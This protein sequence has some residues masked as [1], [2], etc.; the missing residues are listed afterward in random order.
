MAA[1][2]LD[3]LVIGGGPT[4]VTAAT[5]LTQGGCR[6]LLLDAEPVG[7][8]RR[9]AGETLRAARAGRMADW[10]SW[11][12]RSIFETAQLQDVSP[13]LRVHS[14]AG[15]LESWKKVNRI[16]S[17]GFVAVGRDGPGGLS[18]IW[19]AMT[20]RLD[21]AQLTSLGFDPSEFDE[22]YRRV[23]ARIGMSGPP[24]NAASAVQDPPLEPSASAALFMERS[25]RRAAASGLAFERPQ[26]AVLSKPRGPGG[27]CTL[28][29]ACLW[30]CPVGAIYDAS[31][32]LEA[33][34]SSP[35]FS[36]ESARVVSLARESGGWRVE[37]LRGREPITFRA[38]VVVVAAGH[39]TTSRL[40]LETLEYYERPIRFENSPAF[41]LAVVLPERVG[42]PTAERAFGMAQLVF[43]LKTDGRPQDEIFGAVYDAE[44]VA[45]S[46]LYSATFLSPG[47]IRSIAR[48]LTPAV[49][50]VFCYLPGGL[51]ENWMRLER[52]ASGPRLKV[53]GDIALDLKSALRR[54]ARR[55]SSAFRRLGAY[56]IPGA[57]RAY[58]P[59]AEVH[60][61]CGLA[62]SGIA[63]KD[64][65]IVGAPGLY[66]VDLSVLPSMPARHP[67]FTA[68]ANAD[69]IS[70]KI[71]SAFG[72]CRT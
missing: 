2:E 55:V 49:S 71:A 57:S 61:G 67:T 40:V 7:P 12:G 52:S 37:S 9:F 64:G 10:R 46:D 17:R 44:S 5:T 59:G 29:G 45:P 70:Q 18:A 14:T 39:L 3:A 35:N 62:I 24:E 33:L 63:N 43:S 66:A 42:A 72:R 6:T 11:L 8:T 21:S 58:A 20:P 50:L 56:E 65:A 38:P 60:A 30:G 32:D 23:A 15:E 13:K 69:R 26:M 28:C 22:S 1:A 68:M 31:F 51:S 16:E 27:A 36:Y 53:S 41:A 48:A 4:G 25:A 47:G 34:K 19:G 54:S